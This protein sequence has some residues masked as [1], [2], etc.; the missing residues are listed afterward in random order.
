MKVNATK[1]F[2]L[3][4]GFSLCVLGAWGVTVGPTTVGARTDTD[5]GTT[6]GVV[7]TNLALDKAQ[8]AVATAAIP[9]YPAVRDLKESAR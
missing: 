2:S 7:A 9:G 8:L 1:T 5:R 4:R 6:I 3:A